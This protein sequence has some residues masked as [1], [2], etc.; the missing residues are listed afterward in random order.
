LGNNLVNTDA[1]VDNGQTSIDYLS[2]NVNS[3][4]NMNYEQVYLDTLDN[5][6]TVLSLGTFSTSGRRWGYDRNCLFWRGSINGLNHATALFKS[7]RN[8][9]Y[10]IIIQY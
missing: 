10:N 7:Y 6:Q 1:L 9:K 5:G 2:Y 3:L 4:E 8:T